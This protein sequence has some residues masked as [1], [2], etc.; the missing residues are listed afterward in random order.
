MTSQLQYVKSKL[1]WSS[2]LKLNSENQLI[3]KLVVVFLELAAEL[4]VALKP[5][6][7]IWMQI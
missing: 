7:V 3:G 5:M 4:K 2:L 1:E 6:T